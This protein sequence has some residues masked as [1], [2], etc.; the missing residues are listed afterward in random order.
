MAA[1]GLR[2]LAVGSEAT[3]P[4]GG[5]EEVSEQGAM[6]RPP[7]S[8]GEPLFGP[9]DIAWAMVHGLVLLAAVLGLYIWASQG[10]TPE[11]ARG[12]AVA[13]LLIGNLALALSDT[14]APSS[15]LFSGSRIAFWTI[16][17]AAMAALGALLFAPGL[18]GIFHVSPPTLPLHAAAVACG[19]A[20][21]GLF[22]LAAAASHALRRSSAKEAHV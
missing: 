10:H 1:D 2:V 22:G 17:L 13:A 9:L 19:L 7:R 6:R 15:G 8:P 20:G 12:A 5:P 16:T 4:V 18:S 14:S 3:G 21:G 11:E